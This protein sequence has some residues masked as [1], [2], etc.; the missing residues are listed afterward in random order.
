MR[1]VIFNQKGGVGKTTIACNL[2]ALSAAA[3]KRTL[4]VDLD[5]Q[6][7]STQYMLGDKANSLELTLADYYEETLNFIWFP[8]EANAY[9]HATP[10]D[11]LAILPAHETLGELMARLESRYKIGKLKDVLDQLGEYDAVY[12]DTPPAFNFY[13]LSA[14]IAA[15]R[16]LI[17][18]DCDD[19]S[20][21]ALYRLLDRV[22]EV[23][24]DH[25]RN[26]NVEGIVVNHFQERAKLP[27]ALVAELTGEGLPILENRLSHSVIIRESHQKATP[28]VNYA[29]NHKVSIQFRSL[30]HELNG[31][32]KA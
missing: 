17:P 2:A 22:R 19:F 4:L 16:C 11:R 1:R 18:F 13:T 9:V 30:F 25:N 20:R 5:P 6:A 14:L 15:D 32:E 27:K 10:I 23:Q 12:I 7:N 3:G 21:R 24:Q 28:L 31:E 26:L 8:K 29:P